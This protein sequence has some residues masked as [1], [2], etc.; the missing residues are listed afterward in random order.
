[1]KIKNKDAEIYDKNRELYDSSAE[2]SGEAA[3][4]N[5]EKK[6]LQRDGG[7]KPMYLKD[8]HAQQVDTA[9]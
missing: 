4:E 2:G 8:V 3:P 1:M 7:T 5:E 9:A 6:Q